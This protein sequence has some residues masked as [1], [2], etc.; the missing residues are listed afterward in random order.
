MSAMET[1]TCGLWFRFIQDLQVCAYSD[2]DWAASKE[3]Q[4]CMSG[5][6]VMMNGSP[7]I[8]KSRLQ[9]AV[10]LS[11]AEAE[12]VALS[13]CIQEVIWIKSLLKELG[14]QKESAITVYE[15]NLSAI[16]IAKNDGY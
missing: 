7:V 9:R 12:Y 10:A 14:I 11:T 1:K 13:L 16:A 8:F 15:D 2:A 6:M 4:R 3:N 5:I